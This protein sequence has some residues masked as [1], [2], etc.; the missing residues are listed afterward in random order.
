MHAKFQIQPIGQVRK[1]GDKI[2]IQLDDPYFE[3]LLNI[4]GF[5]HLQIVWWG[6]LSD[7][8]KDRETTCVEGLYKHAPGKI[9]VFST[10]SPAR[11]NPILISTIQV[12]DIDQKLGI[13]YTP[14]IDA[15]PETPILD[16]K[17]YFPMERVKECFVPEWFRHWP[18][19]AEDAVSFNWQNEI[20]SDIPN[21]RS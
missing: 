13:I 16:I 9:G 4:E 3:G 15:V 17:P 19:W 6:H 18:E 1:I 12:L 20:N 21:P 7:K 5:S 10:R 2:A 11:P 14:F 8:A